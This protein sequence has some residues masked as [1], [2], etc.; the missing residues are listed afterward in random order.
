MALGKKKNPILERGTSTNISPETKDFQLDKNLNVTPPADI[1]K[2]RLQKEA[3]TQEFG[4]DPTKINVENTQTQTA[5]PIKPNFTEP[6]IIRNQDTGEPTFVK[7]PDGRV[8]S[9]AG[10][11]PQVVQ[12]LVNASNAKTATPQGAIEGT[13]AQAIRQNAQQSQ[14]AVQGIGQQVAP[15][16]DVTDF[17]SRTGTDVALNAGGL[18]G[19]TGIGTAI[20]SFVSAGAAAGTIASPVG[21]IVGASLGLLA[22]IGFVLGR[23]AL[24]RHNVV[25]RANNVFTESKKSNTFMLN[26]AN[27]GKTPPADLVSSYNQNFANIIAARNELRE[28]AKTKVGASL[29]GAQDEL[30]DIEIYLADERFRRAQF[31]NAILQPNPDI[32]YQIEPDLKSNE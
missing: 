21:T 22:G 18:I 13:D 11:K 3:N 26:L 8:I 6:E 19:A 12:D 5:A 24:S 29:S 7:F 25:K 10:E 1:E 27:A 2:E 16:P 31:Q 23:I 14:Q 28:Q 15:T 20:G 30:A 32:V 9:I 17:S 4:F